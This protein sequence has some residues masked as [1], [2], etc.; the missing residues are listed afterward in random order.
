M[1]VG[2]APYVHLWAQRVAAVIGVGDAEGAAPNRRWAAFLVEHKRQHVA[3]AKATPPCQTGTCSVD[4]Q[5]R[6]EG[7]R[8]ALT[9]CIWHSEACGSHPPH[10]TSGDRTDD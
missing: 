1:A 10:G 8:S 5:A 3:G 4:V 7:G 2:P 6:C 9:I